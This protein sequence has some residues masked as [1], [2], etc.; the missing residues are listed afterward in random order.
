ML[1][2]NV[3]KQVGILTFAYA[4]FLNWPLEAGFKNNESISVNG[5]KKTNVKIPHLH[6]Y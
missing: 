2:H 1:T 4:R 5:A 3:D 6:L